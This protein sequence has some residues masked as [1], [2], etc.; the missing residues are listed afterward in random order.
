MITGSDLTDARSRAGLT[1]AELAKRLDVTQR[2]IVNW[3]AGQVPRN[4]EARVRDALGTDLAG[5][6][7]PLANISD[8]ALLSELGRRLET[9]KKGGSD[10]RLPETEKSGNDGGADGQSGTGGAPADPG[11]RERRAVD[12]RGG[13]DRSRQR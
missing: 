5:H 11:Q 3:E 1:Q 4:Q 8:L 7:D 10:G 2:T 9:Y 6:V 12:G 13:M